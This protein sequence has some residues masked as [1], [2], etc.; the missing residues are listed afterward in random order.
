MFQWEESKTKTSSYSHRIPINS[1]RIISRGINTKV[2]QSCAA[3]DRKGLFFFS[4]IFHTLTNFYSLV[5][6]NVCL[7]ISG[8]VTENFPNGV[9]LNLKMKTKNERDQLLNLLCEW[10]DAAIHGI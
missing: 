8:P 10:R 1:I 7:S 3:K 4:L 5:N 9:E 2:L 6:A